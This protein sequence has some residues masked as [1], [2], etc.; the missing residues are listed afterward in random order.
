MSRALVLALQCVDSFMRGHLIPPAAQGLSAKEMSFFN[1]ALPQ[2]MMLNC[3][4]R[5]PSYHEWKLK[6]ER[7]DLGGVEISDEE[8]LAHHLKGVRIY[9]DPSF[10]RGMR[11]AGVDDVSGKH[12]CTKDA[13]LFEPIYVRQLSKAQLSKGQ[14]LW[15]TSVEPCFHAWHAAGARARERR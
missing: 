3:T 8:L 12:V 6:A 7:F 1:E 13:S 10:H 5:H 2:M 14:I 9:S 11:N 4:R 15:V